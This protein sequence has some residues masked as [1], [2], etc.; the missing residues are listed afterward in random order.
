VLGEVAFNQR[1]V[2]FA[3]RSREGERDLAEAQLEQSVAAPR[4]AVIVALGRR[5]AQDLDLAR[6]QPQP[7]VGWARISC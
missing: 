4:L 5:A 7:L 6:V 3:G 1:L 2:G